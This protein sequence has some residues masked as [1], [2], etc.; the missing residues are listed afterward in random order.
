MWKKINVGVHNLTKKHWLVYTI[1]VSLPTIWFS[2]ILNFWGIPL[3]LIGIDSNGGKFLTRLGL[4]LT[5]LVIILTFIINLL[6]NYLASKTEQNKL[7]LLQN[8]N[9]FYRQINESVDYICNDKLEQLKRMIP[10]IIDEVEEPPIIITNPDNQLKRIIEQINKCLCVFISQPTEKYNFRDFT[11]TL[12]YNFPLIDN[13]WS[14][15]EGTNEKEFSLDELVNPTNKTTFNYLISSRKPYYFNNSKEDAKRNGQYM[16][17]SQD[18]INNENENDIGS[19]FCY[20]YQIKKNNTVYIDAILSIST[21][22]KRFVPDNDEKKIN[23]VR[24]NIL[25]IVKDHF[26][27]RLSIE[28]SLLYLH[29]LEMKERKIKESA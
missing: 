5:L 4:F 19:I 29:K 20:K 13:N 12:A 10:K 7:E 2:T 28:L 15:L 17:D 18:E 22:Q 6:N 14:W 23:I 9:S 21:N 27:L 11:V 16:Y 26:G 8:E 25:K 24:E 3:N 1:I